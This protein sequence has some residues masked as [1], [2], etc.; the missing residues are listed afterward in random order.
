MQGVLAHDD[1]SFNVRG[2]CCV[3][4]SGMF[5]GTKLRR[6]VLLTASP[7]SVDATKQ[8][9]CAKTKAANIL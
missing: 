7:L 1:W 3:T 8:S 2:K 5:S 4:S 6:D 9:T